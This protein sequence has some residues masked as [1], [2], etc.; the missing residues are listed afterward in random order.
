MSTSVFSSARTS[1]FGWVRRASATAMARGE[2]RPLHRGSAL[3]DIRMGGVG[4]GS[5]ISS[6]LS[7]GALLARR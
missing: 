1:Q 3:G 6:A 7:F 4:A 2:R 5:R